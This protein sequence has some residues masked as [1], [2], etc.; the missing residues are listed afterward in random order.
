MGRLVWI[1]FGAVAGVVAAVRLE[2]PSRLV[3]FAAGGG[4]LAEAGQ[5][6]G[7][8]DP[9]GGLLDLHPLPIDPGRVFGT[10]QRPELVLDCCDRVL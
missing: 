2:A 3:E 4:R 7:Q 9:V 1:G 5:D 10:D 8:L 6:V